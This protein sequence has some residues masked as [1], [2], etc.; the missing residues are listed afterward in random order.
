MGAASI[1][2]GVGAITGWDCC[3]GRT[4][5]ALYGGHGYREMLG[6]QDRFAP[7]MRDCRTC[8][9]RSRGVGTRLVLCVLGGCW[10]S[11]LRDSHACDV[12]RAM[13]GEHLGDDRKWA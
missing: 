11:S 3:G 7:R 10:A 5:I 12:V 6:I 1:G 8:P 13:P 2:V 4:R 9:Q